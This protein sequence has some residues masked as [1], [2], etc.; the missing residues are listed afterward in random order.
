MNEGGAADSAFRL[1]PTRLIETAE[2]D[3]TLVLD[4]GTEK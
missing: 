3:R 4:W 1:F 2:L